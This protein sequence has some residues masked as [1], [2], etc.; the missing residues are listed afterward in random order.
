MHFLTKTE[1]EMY[2]KANT[3]LKQ[4]N[5]AL[6]FYP[7][8]D[9]WVIIDQGHESHATN[10][11]ASLPKVLDAIEKRES[12]VRH[13]SFNS[14]IEEYRYNAAKNALENNGFTLYYAPTTKTWTVFSEAGEFFGAFSKIEE[15]PDDLIKPHE[16]EA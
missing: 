16:K 6:V 9:V 14:P 3:K 5:Q 8:Y 12:E 7:L 15:I 11:H 4:Y 10:V 1:E 13:M 2:H